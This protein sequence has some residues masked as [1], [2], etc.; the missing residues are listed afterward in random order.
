MKKPIL[1]SIRYFLPLLVIYIILILVFSKESFSGDED[2]HMSYAQNIVQG[3]YADTDNPSLRNG[4]GYPLGMSVFVLAK[5]PYIVIKLANAVFLLLAVVFFYKTLSIYL[6]AKKAI[7]LSYVFGLYPPILKWIIYMHSET[8]ALFLVCGFLYFFLKLHKNEANKKR[9]LSLAA[10][11]LGTLALTK[12][13]FAYAIIALFIFYLFVF[14]FKRS[15]KAK[16]SLLVLGIGFLFCIPYLGYTYAVTGEKFLWG[17]QGGEILYW[18][19]TPFENEYGN[20]ISADV[21]LGKEKG[22]YHTTSSIIKNHGA[23]VESLQEYSFLEQDALY[24]KKAIENMKTYPKK[25][26]QNT[27]ASAFRLFF[28]YPYSYTNQKP[29]SFFYILP[30][31]FLVVLI[32]TTLFLGCKNLSLI[33]FEIR[34]IALTGAIFIGGLILLDGRVRHLIPA[35]PLLLFIIAVIN[36]KF[37]TVS[38]KK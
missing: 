31:M 22:D 16:N 33:S 2:R 21:V 6:S 20:W 9:N 32:V 28:N 19:S 23:F 25:Y 38:I 11:F 30:N 5:A 36:D 13:I 24:K 35:I 10:I 34:F 17:T 3:F 7:I 18:R 15:K 1:K 27:V 14:I 8:L 12:V 26:L 37:V 4:P 29:S